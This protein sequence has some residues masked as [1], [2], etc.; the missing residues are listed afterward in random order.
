[1]TLLSSAFK[2]YDKAISIGLTLCSSARRYPLNRTHSTHFRRDWPLDATD[3]AIKNGNTK[4]QSRGNRSEHYTL[5]GHPWVQ[6]LLPSVDISICS[7]RQSNELQRLHALRAPLLHKRIHIARLNALCR[8][9]HRCANQGIISIG[10]LVFNSGEHWIS[11]LVFSQ[12]KNSRGYPS[13]YGAP[14]RWK[15]LT[16][17]IELSPRLTPCHSSPTRFTEVRNW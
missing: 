8:V 11:A 10:L 16:R 9:L 15:A 7:T 4:R 1:M 17:P 12:R 3:N 6:H 13:Y 2:E 5:A 14:R